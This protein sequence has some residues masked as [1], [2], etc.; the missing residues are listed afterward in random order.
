M[1]KSN[2]L[3]LEITEVKNLLSAFDDNVI[4]CSKIPNFSDKKAAGVASRE[5]L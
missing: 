3:S 5:A 4:G 2:N 1:K